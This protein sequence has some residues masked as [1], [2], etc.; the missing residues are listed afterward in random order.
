M[1]P[2]EYALLCRYLEVNDF[3]PNTVKAIRLDLQKWERWFQTANGELYDARRATPRDVADFRRHLR[4][5]RRQAVSTT[6]RCLV[7]LRRYFAFLLREG[8]VTASPCEGLKELRRVEQAPKAID[9]VNVRKILREA[10]VRQDARGLAILSLMVYCGLRVGEVAALELGDLDVSERQGS[11]RVRDGKGRKER[12]VPIPS[13][14]RHALAKYLAVRSPYPIPV[15][16]LARDGAPLRTDGF[17]H[18]VRKYGIA[19]GVRLHPHALR[20]TMATEYL[21][22]TSNDLVGLSQLLG[23]ESIQTTSRY[24]RRT[25]AALAEAASRLS[26]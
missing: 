21:Q 26:Y 12:T 8:F 11:V 16:F 17:R 4:E 22:A 7:T 18:L 24:T 5:V 1:I 2:D 6:N 3:A 15:V 25:E 20:H 10:T 13:E 9:R 19:A 23:H 14:A